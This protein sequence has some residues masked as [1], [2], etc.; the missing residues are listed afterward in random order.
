[1]ESFKAQ[2]YKY[3]TLKFNC[4]CG[5]EFN[6]VNL[7]GWL[8]DPNAGKD[9]SK[10]LKIGIDFCCWGWKWARY[11]TWSSMSACRAVEEL[12][13]FSGETIPCVDG[14]KWCSINKKMNIVW[15]VVQSP[16]FPVCY[17]F[18]FSS[19]KMTD[20]RLTVSELI[21]Y[22]IL[23]A[24]CFWTVLVIRQFSL[25]AGKETTPQDLQSKRKMHSPRNKGNLAMQLT[26]KL[27]MFR[28]LSV[29]KKIQVLCLE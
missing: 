8:I 18:W 3:R 17:Q 7:A 12:L 29:Q 14:L 19:D 22:S 13:K 26:W 6:F 1:M 5:P 11:L 2:N 23:F 15:C 10:Q 21:R 25:R 24:F 16:C 4:F 28:I 20:V 27:F 9:V